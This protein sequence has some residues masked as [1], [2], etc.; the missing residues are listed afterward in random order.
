MCIAKRVSRIRDP[1]LP[2]HSWSGWLGCR[3]ERECGRYARLFTAEQHRRSRNLYRRSMTSDPGKTRQSAP[4]RPLSRTSKEGDENF[5]R[6]R[7]NIFYASFS[8]LRPSSFFLPFLSFQENIL[9]PRFFISLTRFRTNFI[10][11]PPLSLSLSVYIH[12]FFYFLFIFHCPEILLKRIDLSSLR[13]Y[14]NS[15]RH[16]VRHPPESFVLPS[17]LREIISRKSDRSIISYVP[18]ELRQKERLYARVL[19]IDGSHLT[20]GRSTRR[21]AG[22]CIRSG[23]G[24][25]DAGTAAAAVTRSQNLYRRSMTPTLARRS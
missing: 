25:R 6:P 21:I 13:T 23:G 10:S 7:A 14:Q 9:L 5:L 11:P 1:S 8:L 16:R 19:A 24:G 3:W 12:L 20:K 4:S 17:Q 22:R 15:K 2:E 18:L